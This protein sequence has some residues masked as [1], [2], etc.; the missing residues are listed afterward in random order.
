MYPSG[1]WY[2]DPSDMVTMCLRDSFTIS[3]PCD[4]EGIKVGGWHIFPTTS[5][6]VSILQCGRCLYLCVYLQISKESL[7]GSFY[8]SKMI[9]HVILRLVWTGSRNDSGTPSMLTYKLP[10]EGT[11]EPHVCTLLHLYLQNSLLHKY[12]VNKIS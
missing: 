9:P 4:H 5:L 8:R 2:S 12:V 6:K 3:L 11:I 10:V 1:E 7:E